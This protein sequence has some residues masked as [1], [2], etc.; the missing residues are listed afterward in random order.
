MAQI[1]TAWLLNKGVES[2]MSNG[3][4]MPLIGFNEVVTRG[5]LLRVGS[6]FP[7]YD[8]SAALLAVLGHNAR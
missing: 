6:F 2:P 5:S 7:S 1:A 8:V 4:Q 3:V